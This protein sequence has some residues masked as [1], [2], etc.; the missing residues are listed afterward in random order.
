M[1][2]LYDVDRNGFIEQAD[3]ELI[4]HKTALAMEHQPD[5]LEY[6]TV[7]NGYMTGWARLVQLGDS[8]GDQRLTLDEYCAAYDKMLAQPA[9]FT[10]MMISIVR[11]IIT[12]LD[13]DKDGKV[14]VPEYAAYLT[15]WGT[16]EAEIAE[17]F[18]RLDHNG[19]GYLTADELRQNAEEFFFSDDPAA[20]GNWLVGPY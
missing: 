4:A 10:P 18:R 9:Q 5:S 3:F 12:L 6:T 15:A 14:S 1:F 11:T 13:T 2:T 16:T 19:D 20:P 17:T 7:H 8:D